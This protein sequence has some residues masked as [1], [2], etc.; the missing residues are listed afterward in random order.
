LTAGRPLADGHTRCQPWPELFDGVD[1]T[2]RERITQGAFQELFPVVAPTPADGA[3]W[4]LWS[5]PS[6]DSVATEGRL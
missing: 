1:A 2:A 3:G 4:W 6:L 5:R